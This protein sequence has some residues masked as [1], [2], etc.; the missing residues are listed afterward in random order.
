MSL[1]LGLDIGAVDVLWEQE[2]RKYYF[3]E[4]NTACSLDHKRVLDFFKRYIPLAINDKYQSH[5][6]V[7]RSH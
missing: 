4:A 7:N 5:S 2:A 6:L 1:N 3:L